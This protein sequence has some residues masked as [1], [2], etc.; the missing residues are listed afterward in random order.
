MKQSF[1]KMNRNWRDTITQAATSNNHELQGLNNENGP[2]PGDQNA[3]ASGWG[4][5]E[6][7]YK[8]W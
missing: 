2:S 5:T 8:Q 7:I 1:I 6:N 4:S 3:G